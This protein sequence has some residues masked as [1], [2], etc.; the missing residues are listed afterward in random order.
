MRLGF[1]DE[2][3]AGNDRVLDCRLSD[4]GIKWPWSYRVYTAEHMRFICE[5]ETR[6]NDSVGDD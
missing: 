1:T 5:M 3:L 2:A 6:E 4:T